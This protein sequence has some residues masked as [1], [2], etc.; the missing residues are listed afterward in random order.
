MERRHILL[1][2]QA[3]YDF[4]RRVAFIDPFKFIDIDESATSP[5][6]FLEK[7]GWSP[8]GETLIRQQFKIGDKH[9]SAIAAYSFAGFLCWEIV[10]G[11]FT[12]NHF[13]Q[14]LQHTLRP[15]LTDN[16]LL[17]DNAT[18]HKTRTALDFLDRV[19]NGQY[20]FAPAYSPDL[21]PIERGFANVKRWLRKQELEAVLDPLRYLNQ[22]FER[23]SVRSDIGLA[24]NMIYLLS[25]VMDSCNGFRCVI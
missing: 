10:E 19:S 12:A 17:L 21:K 23:Y 4:M 3:R 20:E 24:G 14:F 15:Y 11:S 5:S 7:Y 22:A 13:S 8:K 9:Y 16:T 2:H 25:I 18:V 6:Q 1:D